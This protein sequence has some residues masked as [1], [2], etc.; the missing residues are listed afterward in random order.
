VT[1]LAGLAELWLILVLSFALGCVFMVENP[2]RLSFVPELVG[3]DLIPNAAG[4][5]ILSLTV[6]RL[7]GPAIAGVLIAVVGSGWV[8]VINAVS[9][10][11]VIAGLISIRPGPREDHARPRT[12]WTGAGR[13]GL[14]YVAG[15]PSLVAVFATF[16]LVSTFGLT[17]TTTLTLF[18]GRVFDSGS[19]GLGFMSAALAAGMIAGALVAARRAAPTPHLVVSG[20]LLFALAEFIAALAPSYGS[21]LVLL[22]PAGFCF[23]I[24][25]T[26][27]SAYVQMD[28]TDAV[29][30]RVMAVYT[31]IS[32]GG[33]P[34]GSPIIGWI[35]DQAGARV[36]MITGAAV[37]AAA[38]AGAAIWFAASRQAARPPSAGEPI[39]GR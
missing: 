24:L 9:F 33:I 34:I 21:F 13:A 26:A 27:V 1:V 39:T 37:S 20:A 18:A 7:A 5:N 14:R 11:I 32:M 31:V 23:M 4:L 17:F 19:S 29:R 36:G 35:C 15:R 12:P 30:G 10:S 28:V 22:A 2:A 3:R 8:F 16:G 6:A 38:G 25:N